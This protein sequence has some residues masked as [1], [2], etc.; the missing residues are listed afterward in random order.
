[1]RSFVLYLYISWGRDTT[2][3]YDDEFLY[4]LTFYI[5]PFLF[6]CQYLTTSCY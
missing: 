1:M 6:R 4:T 2:N 3:A 5:Y